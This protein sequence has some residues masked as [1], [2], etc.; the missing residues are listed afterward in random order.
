MVDINHPWNEGWSNIHSLCPLYYLL[1]GGS[2]ALSFHGGSGA[3]SFE[4]F[5]G[6]RG[7]GPFKKWGWKASIKGGLILSPLNL[8][9]RPPPLKRWCPPSF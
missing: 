9:W 2:E 1:N 6:G 4:F 7:L 5:G 8:G 3:I